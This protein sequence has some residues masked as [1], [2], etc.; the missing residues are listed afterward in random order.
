MDYFSRIVKD[1]KSLKIQGA[2]AVASSALD[3]VSYVAK[4]SKAKNPNSLIKEI[5][6]AKEVLYNTRPTEPL[7]RNS[8]RYI[9]YSMKESGISDT[10]KLKR[11]VEVTADE[12]IFNIK[13]D[14]DRIAEIGAGK[15]E[16]GM[17]LM[18]HC[19]SSAVTN[20]FRKA[21][22]QGKKFSVICTETRPHYQ[23]RITAKELVKLGIP[24]TM[25]VDGAMSSFIKK[26]D[27][28]FVGCDLITSDIS[29]INKIG[30]FYLSLAAKRV[31]IPFYCEAE[32]AKFDP[33]TMFGKIEQ[34]EQ[35]SGKEIWPNAPKKLKISNPVF[36]ITPRENISAF[37]TQEGIV[38]PSAITDL[39][40]EKLPW[41]FKGL[42]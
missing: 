41:I 38:P 26:A 31:G 9:L 37:I 29:M 4:N 13:K 5:E 21:K 27:A 40:N 23:G 3:A 33:E 34:I 25:I 6:K 30:T 42:R 19:H 16:S 11:L 10:K 8:L 2:T 7:M 35:R 20:T 12:F 28:A 22:E 24:T 32:L 15:I 14:K 17:T 39:I 1:I 36:D 18:T